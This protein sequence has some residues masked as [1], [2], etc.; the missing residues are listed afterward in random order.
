LRTLA[1]LLPIS[2]GEI[3][4]P[5]RPRRGLAEGGRFSNPPSAER[6]SGQFRH[7][8]PSSPLIVRRIADFDKL[9]TSW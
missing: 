9:K 1:C 5:P 6:K 2:F 7:L 4:D 3:E 8:D